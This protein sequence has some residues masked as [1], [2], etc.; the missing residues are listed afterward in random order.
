[1]TKSFDIGNSRKTARWFSLLLVFTLFFA[2]A[3]SQN[4]SIDDNSTSPSNASI[5]N[6]T[7]SP[8][9]DSTSPPSDQIW[10]PLNLGLVIAAIVIAVIICV[11]FIVLMCVYD[12]LRCLCCCCCK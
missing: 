11:A 5:D 3:L 7:N 8:N 6:L 10:T 1:M 9:T 12:V 4:I 2:I